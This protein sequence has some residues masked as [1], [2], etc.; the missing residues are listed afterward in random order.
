VVRGI[1][2][3]DHLL[4]MPPKAPPAGIPALQADLRGTTT[5]RT[6]LD[7]HRT[8]TSCNSCHKHIDPIG[9]ALENFDAAGRWRTRYANAPIDASGRLPNGKTFSDIV[10]FKQE[11]RNQVDLVAEN[12]VRK[13]LVY[14]TGRKMGPLDEGEITEL[15]QRLKL[16]G[17]GMRDLIIAVCQSR[18]FTCK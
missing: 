2:V 15:V 16:T 6:M 18:I 7:R 10:G 1:Y 17:Y 11:M 5:V 14:C 3:L 8:D 12:L 9:F 13:L 4:G